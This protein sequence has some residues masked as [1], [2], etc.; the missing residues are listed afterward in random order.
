MKERGRDITAGYIALLRKIL[1]KLDDMYQTGGNI[2][3]LTVD[4]IRSLKNSGV[5]WDIKA[6]IKGRLKERECFLPIELP[7]ALSIK[8]LEKA[9]TGN[10]SPAPAGDNSV[11]KGVRV[12]GNSPA[13][14]SA[15]IASELA[16]AADAGRNHILVIR[17]ASPQWSVVLP[18]IGG[19]VSEGGGMLSHLAILAREYGVPYTAGCTGA[20][21]HIGNDDNLTLQTDGTVTVERHGKAE[22]KDE[23]LLKLKEEP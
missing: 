2:F 22:K 5:T 10:M 17:N 20:T 3:Y 16:D 4:E 12:S 6:L 13:K 18:F 8:D 21:S 9:G 11:L 15:L 19:I 14:G 1:L 7:L 23:D